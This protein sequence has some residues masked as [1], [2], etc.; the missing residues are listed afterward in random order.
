MNGRR[1]AKHINQLWTVAM[2]AWLLSAC[3]NTTVATVAPTPFAAPT[4]T[5]VPSVTATRLPATPT[6]QSPTPAPESSPTP[7][8]PKPSPSANASPSKLAAIAVPLP[9]GQ[10]GIGF[11]DLVFDAGLGKVIAPAGRTGRVD[12]VDPA[13]L[14]VT[15]ID[16]F[17]TQK[18][19]DGGHGVGTTSADAGEGL[20]FAIDRT[21]GKLLVVDPIRR[22]I[23]G[24]ASLAGSPDYVRYVGPT[25]ELWVTEPD[26]EQIEV[27][28]LSN[29]KNLARV[30]TIAVTGGPESLVI[31]N[32]R[33]LAYTHLW[34]DRT[35]AIDLHSRSVRVTWQNG[36]RDSRGIALDE[37]RA[38]LFAA[39]AEGKAV[40]LD[41]AHDGKQ[42]G[43]LNFGSAVDVIGYSPALAHLYLP[44]SASA[45]LGIVG[46]AGDGSLT[47]LGTA[48]LALGVHCAVADNRGQVW[49]CDPVHGQLLLVKDSL[50][51]ARR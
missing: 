47:L 2:L 33:K 5:A 27:F 14:A 32:T 25:H 46:V 26:A 50:A 1:K 6:P 12:L 15:A 24:S 11:D 9:D 13:T 21:A 39:C 36:C 51:A 37:R 23:V 17:S 22:T 49:V 34:A 7:V 40:V 30:T 31:D 48:D 16:G 20:L 43:N 3:A 10:G 4:A 42:L 44:G 28:S 35:V 41:V 19:F 29:G 18:Q 45:N 38:Y 8:Q